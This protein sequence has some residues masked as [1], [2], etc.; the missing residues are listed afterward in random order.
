MSK[1]KMNIFCLPL[2]VLMLGGC[3]PISKISEDNGNLHKLEGKWLVIKIDDKILPETKNDED[4]SRLPTLIFN[5]KSNSFTGDDK[6]G[7][8]KGRFSSVSD[9]IEFSFNKSAI[10]KQTDKEN[11]RPY[12]VG[13]LTVDKMDVI[14]IHMLRVKGQKGELVLA[15]DIK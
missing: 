3:S 15:K 13:Q 4:V 9:K 14:N 7:V 6:C 12:L 10:C 2:V 5:A 8:F 1:I 11:I